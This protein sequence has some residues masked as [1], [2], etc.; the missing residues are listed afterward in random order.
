MRGGNFNRAASNTETTGWC[1][2]GRGTRIH[3]RICFTKAG[4]LVCRLW[5]VIRRKTLVQSRGTIL[6]VCHFGQVLEVCF[7]M[8]CSPCGWFDSFLYLA[9]C[10]SLKN[11]FRPTDAIACVLLCCFTIVC[12]YFLLYLYFSIL[13]QCEWFFALWFA[14]ALRWIMYRAVNLHRLLCSLLLWDYFVLLWIFLVC[15]KLVNLDPVPVVVS[16]KIIFRSVD[17]IL[18]CTYLLFNVSLSLSLSVCV[19]DNRLVDGTTLLIGSRP[20]MRRLRHGW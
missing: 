11:I 14:S 12:V 2:W 1:A 9:G 7:A 13:I 10:I 6:V 20:G 3:R 4:T 8:L 17:A 15:C 5:C 16:L 19:V 18:L